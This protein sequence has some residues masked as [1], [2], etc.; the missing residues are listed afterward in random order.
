MTH[1]FGVSIKDEK[2]LE[3][4]HIAVAKG[5]NSQYRDGIV[6]IADVTGLTTDVH[7][8]GGKYCV[9]GKRHDIWCTEANNVMKRV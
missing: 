2:A 8:D 9:K 4:R 5:Y 6:T 7:I 3:L 1:G